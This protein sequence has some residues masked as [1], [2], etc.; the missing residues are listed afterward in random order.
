MSKDSIGRESGGVEKD[1]REAMSDK[2]SAG[3]MR[4]ARAL[5]IKI[6]GLE[7]GSG[8][9]GADNPANSKWL[10]DACPDDAEIIDRETAAPELLAAA[11]TAWVTLNTMC[12]LFREED[13]GN[14]RKEELANSIESTKDI[15]DAAIAKAKGESNA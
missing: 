2:P 6:H 12:A 4:A 3:A 10:D 11:K 9:H 7:S 1:L 15:L 8:V 13:M 14:P 5:R